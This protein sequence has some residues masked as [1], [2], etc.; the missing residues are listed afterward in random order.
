ME[1]V[2]TKV[3]DSGCSVCE[4]MSRF[5]RSVFEG[6]P[7]L[8]YREITFDDLQNMGNNQTKINLYQTL[9]RYA[10]SPSYEIEFPTYV[11]LSRTGRYLGHLQGSLTIRKLRE[12]VKDILTRTS[13]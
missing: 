2:V 9:E 8:H 6:F 7:E 10:V 12:G 3:Y 5:D 11:F 1:V 13:E 4:T